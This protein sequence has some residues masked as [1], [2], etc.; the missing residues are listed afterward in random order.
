MK[1]AFNCN[2]ANECPA[3]CD[4]EQDCYCRV[5]GSCVNRDSFKG[6]GRRTKKEIK[7][8]K[9]SNKKICELLERLKD[10]GDYAMYMGVLN[11][12][13]IYEDK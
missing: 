2:H 9:P 12:A 13:K 1:S 6:S 5:E 11:A 7:D 3:Q 4:C 8:F 10:I